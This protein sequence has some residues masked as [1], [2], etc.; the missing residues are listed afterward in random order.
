ML[1]VTS[2]F[3]ENNFYKFAYAR[4]ICDNHFFNLLTALILISKILNSRRAIYHCYLNAQSQYCKEINKTI[5]L[6]LFI[7]TAE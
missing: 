2:N 3:P 4:L 5:K 7:F 1:S 6:Q